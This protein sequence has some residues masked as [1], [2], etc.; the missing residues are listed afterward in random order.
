MNAPMPDAPGWLIQAAALAFPA[1]VLCGLVALWRF[2][3]DPT[4]R[5]R[6]VQLV[7][8]A[9]GTANSGSLAYVT[10]L[11]VSTWAVWFEALGGRL[12]EWLILAYIGTFVAGGAVRQWTGSRERV[13]MARAQRPASGPQSLSVETTSTD[14]TT[15]TPEDAP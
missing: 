13:G 3:R 9:D 8:D 11:L 15:V 12:S 10:A 7:S 5:F 6:L 2:D 4:S 14:R 1:L